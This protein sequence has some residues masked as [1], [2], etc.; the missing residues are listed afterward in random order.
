MQIIQ[1]TCLLSAWVVM[2]FLRFLASPLNPSRSYLVVLFLLFWLPQCEPLLHVLLS[3]F[4]LL[5]T[6]SNFSPCL[7]SLPC[8]F[9]FDRSSANHHFMCC[10]SICSAFN[11]LPA[12]MIILVTTI[13]H[14][15][16]KE[17]GGHEG[18]ALKRNTLH[19]EQRSR[20]K[21]WRRRMIRG[22]MQRKG[23]KWRRRRWWWWRRRRRRKRRRRKRRRRRCDDFM[24][25]NFFTFDWHIADCRERRSDLQCQ[26]KCG[27]NNNNRTTYSYMQTYARNNTKM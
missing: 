1:L 24:E 19:L 9:C 13:A 10:D 23:R 21:K 17:V 12:M 2:Q 5:P 8:S 11:P 22:R 26:R 25:E 3:V 14:N 20:R 4:C 16:G 6:P 15:P 27:L 7:T 18:S